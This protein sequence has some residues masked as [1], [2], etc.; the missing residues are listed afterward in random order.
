[1]SEFLLSEDGLIISLL[2]D[3]QDDETYYFESYVFFFEPDGSVLASSATQ[4]VNGTYR[5]FRDDGRTE[6]RMNFPDIRNFDELDDDWY[7]RSIDQNTIRFD[8]NEDKLEF[9]R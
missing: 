1:V 6:L 3:D 9:Q 7:F 8:D 5:V 2:T 4:T